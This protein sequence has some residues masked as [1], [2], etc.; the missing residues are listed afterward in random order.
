M[1]NIGTD[2]GRE[3]HVLATAAPTIGKV[4]TAAPPGL[5]GFDLDRQPAVRAEAG[6]LGPLWVQACSLAGRSHVEGPNPS[7]GQDSYSYRLSDDGTLAVLAVADGLG[8]RARSH[9]GAQV[10]AVEACARFCEPS[11]RHLL[12]G[13]IGRVAPDSSVLAA[14]G[15]VQR[16]LEAVGLRGSAGS[17]VATTL[18][19]AMVALDGPEPRV[20]FARV[21]DPSA[22]L[23]VDGRFTDR[24]MVFG[25]PPT[26]AANSVSACLPMRSPEREV[27]I[28]RVGALPPGVAV[29]LVT[30]G[31]GNDLASSPQLRQWFEQR[32]VE[33]LDAA[34][35]ID[36]LRY[37]R[38]G[39]VDDRTAL[40]VYTTPVD[41]GRREVAGPGRSRSRNRSSPRHRPTGARRRPPRRRGGGRPPP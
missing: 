41:A 23:L 40:V 9:V 37:R 27:E 12:D 26:G 36:T 1:S 29:V 14:M 8:S 22:L 25:A 2:R 39:S 16:R 13:P 34:G 11:V 30:D 7:S 15:A 5:P 19:V 28:V 24:S 20:T 21:G 32:W 4:T 6:R 33:P 3:F 18:L 10:A 17:D 35:M 38:Q 31:V